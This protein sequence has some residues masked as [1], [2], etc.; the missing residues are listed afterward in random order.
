[1]PQSR[2]IAVKRPSNTWRVYSHYAIEEGIIR[3]SYTEPIGQLPLG[4][5]EDVCKKYGLEFK[6]YRPGDDPSLPK[7]FARIRDGN[8]TDVL[9]FVSRHGA[10]GHDSLAML[11][12][13]RE[14][15]AGGDPIDWILAHAKTV[16]LCLQLT[17][18][19]Q[20][21][22]KT[23]IETCLDAQ[24]PG[25]QLTYAIL[26]EWNS[27]GYPADVPAYKDPIELARATRRALVNGNTAYVYRYWHGVRVHKTYPVGDEEVEK[28]LRAEAR[29]V[30]FNALVE[31][32][33]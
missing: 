14:W 25:A 21:K 32:I 3:H 30:G 26:S 7:K 17:E 2:V 13:H 18:L 1:V 5:I 28:A 20:K 29:V 27:D 9:K 11:Q 8:E 31:V 10:L 33:Y 19:I 22:D 15:C 12:G 23:G 6:D 4:L 16:A 24:G